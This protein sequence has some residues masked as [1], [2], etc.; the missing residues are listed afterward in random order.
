MANSVHLFLKANGADI[1]GESAETSLGREGSIEC[2]HYE[3]ALATARDAASGVAI[4]RRQYQP[5]QIRKRI[6]KA[7]PLLAKALINNEAIE[8]TFRFYRPNPS[9]DG[10]TE[11]F[12]TVTLKNARLTALTQLMRDTLTTPDEPPLEDVS[13]SFTGITLTITDGGITSVDSIGGVRDV[14]PPRSLNAKRKKRR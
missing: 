8:A 11:Q 6:D 5:L 2:L 13:F 9:G 3:Q 1:R 14:E 7:S 4:G 12:Y 10:T